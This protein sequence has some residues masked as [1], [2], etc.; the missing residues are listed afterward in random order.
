MCVIGALEALSEMKK[1]HK[2]ITLFMLLA[3]FFG[4]LGVMPALAAGPGVGWSYQRTITLSAGTPSANFQV[5]VQLV[6]AAQHANMNATDGKDLRFY[7]ATDTQADYWIETWNPA[8][9]STI[10]VEVPTAGTTSLTMYYGNASATAVSNG[11]NTFIAFDDF[12][13]ASVDTSK[14]DVY[15][16]NASIVVSGGS[17]TVYGGDQLISKTSFA[18]SSGTIIETVLSSNV[19]YGGG[20]RASMSGASSLSGSGTFFTADEPTNS[21]FAVWSN[22]RDSVYGIHTIH[23][24]DG[25]D[26]GLNTAQYL[27]IAAAGGPGTWTANGNV[28]GAAFETGRLQYFLNY[29]SRGISVTNIPTATMYPLI[30]SVLDP[31][32]I[33][34]FR[35]RKFLNT[36]NPTATVGAESV[37]DATAPSLTSFTRQT[38]ATNPTNA[39]TLVFR[40]TFSED[41][42]NVDA[43]DFAVN[44][45]TT[46]T[47][48]NVATVSAS[49]YDITVSGGDLAG[50]N[51]VVGIDL[52]GGQNIQDLAGNAL[53]AGEPATD[54]T[55]TLNNVAPIVAST[56]LSTTYT[57]TGPGN[58]TVTFDKDVD[59]PAGN[60]GTDDVT[61]PANYLLVN[62]GANG[63]VN[64]ASCAGGVV[65]DDTQ[66][67]VSSVSYNNA[68]FTSTV[69][70]ASTLPV[71][72]YRLFVCGTTSIVDFVGNPLNG[73]SDYTFDFTVN[74][75]PTLLPATGFPQ[76]QVTQLAQQP[77]SKAYASTDLVLEIPSLNQKMTI[78][79]VPQTETSWD[80]T[81][82]G[83]SAGWL[84]GSA[85]PTWQ[86][87]TVLTGHVWDSF[88]QP[89]PFAELKNLK[90]GDQV[91]IHAYGLT[92]T[93]E[94]RESKSY[95]AKTA[96]SKVFQHE[97]LDWVTLMTCETYNPF[98]GDYFF[99]R[100]VRAVLVSVK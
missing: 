86:G 8:G 5:M 65:A 34:T 35:V 13:G 85:F 31:F 100:A 73:G 88:N 17:V 98:N 83:N 91:L 96:V 19:P 45:T 20:S 54:E 43:A 70:L 67:T 48:T 87:N 82:L 30:N 84:N 24:G 57:G 97:E 71:G 25:V 38:P 93:Y 22:G 72:S 63:T 15:D 61:N 52:A 18:M 62:K 74:A 26:N 21:Q 9:T 51:G 2:I 75:A 12:S 6:G 64:T 94:V 40:A 7:D 39:D 4:G 29:V 66:V 58:F 99:R 46:A 3:L 89:G 14:W 92:Y 53:P 27:A 11:D 16:P 36:Y 55:Y 1:L 23:D 78:V 41:V 80:V 56:S 59:D 79:G 47:V 90:F 50:F 37:Y 10:W 77:A 42:Q 33:T 28:L 69:T 95:W 32:S 44:G 68:T 60:T 76:G 81:W 49:V